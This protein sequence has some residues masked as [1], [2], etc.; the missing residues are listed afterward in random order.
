M[1]KTTLQARD[2]M[3]KNAI[4]DNESRVLL[5]LK[6]AIENTNEAFVTIDENH[7]V[8]FFNKAAERIF[9]YSRDDVVGQD[10]DVI[11]SSTCSR[12]HRKAVADP[13]P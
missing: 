8:V 13:N 2:R 12:N 10:L 9:G 1:A 7:E 4:G 3:K 6:H 5:I 11:M